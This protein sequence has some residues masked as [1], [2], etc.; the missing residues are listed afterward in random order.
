MMVAVSVGS[1][2]QPPE[3]GPRA[4]RS[5]GQEG[6]LMNEVILKITLI[7]IS[8]REGNKNCEKTRGQREGKSILSHVR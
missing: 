2:K 7:I 3:P 8:P 5:G 1:W 4:V 6:N